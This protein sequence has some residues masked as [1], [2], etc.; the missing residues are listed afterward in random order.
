MKKI[1]ISLL[2][3]ILVVA[4]ICLNDCNKLYGNTVEYPLSKVRKDDKVEWGL[5]VIKTP[6]RDLLIVSDNTLL[7]ENRESFKVKFDKD[8]YMSTPAYFVKIF[9]NGKEVKSYPLLELEQIEFGT[10]H[11]LIN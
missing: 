2:L 3:I 9:K 4:C 6:D 5:H 8:V 1:I 10:M 11:N 7:Y